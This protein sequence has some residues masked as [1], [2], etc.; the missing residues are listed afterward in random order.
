MADVVGSLTSN[1]RMVLSILGDNTSDNYQ[2]YYTDQDRAD[3]LIEAIQTENKSRRYQDEPELSG[4][5]LDAFLQD[6]E[7]LLIPMKKDP[8]GVYQPMISQEQRERAEKA[9]MDTIE[10][11]LEFK[12]LEDEPKSPTG[13]G[14][15]TTVKAEDKPEYFRIATDVRNA[16]T[17]GNIARLNSL[18][19]GKYLFEKKGENTYL[20]IDAQNPKKVFGPISRLDDAG[21]FFGETNNTSWRKKLAKARVAAKTPAQP[22]KI[23]QDDFNTKWAKLKP[24]QTL[25]GPDGKTYTKK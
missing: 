7:K 11:Q 24:G 10:M 9:I 2:T 6:A 20:I 25:V 16:W 17:D 15:S 1:D 23:T 12:S 4:E 19:E 5:N 14:G 22:A 13:G 21:N 3:L 18:S 8:S